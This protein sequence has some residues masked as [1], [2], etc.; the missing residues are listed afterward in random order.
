M[1]FRSPKA[2]AID[3]TMDRHN[4]RILYAAMWEA[5]R[6]F[7]QISSGGPDSSLYKSTDGGDTWTDI[8]DHKG[9]PQGIKG[10][11]GLAASPAKSGRVWALVEHKDGGLYRS[12]DYGQTWEKVSGKDLLWTRSWYYMHIVAD[13]QD[14]DTV[15]IMNYD[16]WK[17]TDGG[18]NFSQ[19]ATPHG[20]NHDLWI[21]PHNPRRMIEGNDGGAC[22]S[23]NGGDSWSSIYNQPTAQFYHIATDNQFPYRVYGTQ[24]D[25]SSVSVP[26]QSPHGAITWQ[27]CYLAGTGESGHI[28]VHPED[29]NLVYVGAI[30]SSPGGGGALQRYDHRTGQIRLVNVWPEATGGHGAKDQKYRFH[31]TYPDCFFAARPERAVHRRQRGL[32]LDRT[33]SILAADQ[34]GSDARRPRR[35]WSRPAGRSTAMRLAR[36]PTRPSSRSPNR[37]WKRACCGRDRMM[38]CCISRAKRRRLDEHHAEEY[39]GMDDGEHDRAIAASCR[40]CLFRRDALQAGRLPSLSLQDEAITARRW[41]RITGGLPDNDFTRVIRADPAREGLL[42]AGTETGLYVSLDDGANWESFQLN[43][44]VSPIHDLLIKDNDL[45]VGTHGRSIWILDDLTP[46]HQFDDGIAKVC[47]ASVSAACHHRVRPGAV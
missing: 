5:Y 30:G 28:A 14:P 16:L 15:Y 22:V 11:I 2:G 1:L 38:G 9:L 46:L 39:A 26:S 24:Q 36:K 31:W 44:P 45:V 40:D 18:R 17:S 10:K 33:G 29:P 7:W 35:R 12:D 41:T 4:P 3:L 23:L 37:R 19:I 13:T 20:D 6:S 47:G 42:Y 25:N 21:D 43:L 34:P 32:S 27:D 8:S